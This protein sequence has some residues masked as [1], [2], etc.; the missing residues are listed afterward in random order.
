MVQVEQKPTADHA[1]AAK[2]IRLPLGQP[3]ISASP[4]LALID[5]IQKWPRADQA[6]EVL[7]VTSGI[8]PDYGPG[9]SNPYLDRAIETAQRE[10]VVVHSIYFSTAG[11]FGHSLWQINW[12]QNYLLQLSEETGG[13]FFW[14]GTSKPSV[15]RSLPERDERAFSQPARPHVLGSREPRLQAGKIQNRS[16]TRYVGGAFEGLRTGQQVTWSLEDPLIFREPQR[17]GPGRYRP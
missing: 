3:G 6:R 12:G 7:M 14:L 1:L 5:L 11:H 8:D 13:E 15:L 2:T 9:P 16:S 10:G 4:Y 17:L